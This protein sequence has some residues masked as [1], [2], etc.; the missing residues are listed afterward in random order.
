[1]TDLL[2]ELTHYI[3]WQVGDPSK[4]GVTKLNKALWFSDTI[5]YRVTGR[6]ITNTPYVKR[7]FG[8]V[9]RRILPVLDELRAEG[10]IVIRERQRFGYAQREFIALQPATAA[11]FSEQECEIIDEVIAWVC[12]RDT[13]GSISELSHDTIWEAAEEGEEIPLYAVLG[14]AEGEVTDDDREWASKIIA[15]RK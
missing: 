10:K 9:P 11:A 15:A 8:P 3:C 4:L 13:A 7:Q 5:A 12:N 14:V 2:K 6:S 1:M